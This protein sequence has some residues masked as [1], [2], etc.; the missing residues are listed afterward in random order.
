MIIR[1]RIREMFRKKA[2]KSKPP[3]AFKAAEDKTDMS[4]KLVI[5]FLFLQKEM[6]ACVYF[7]VNKKMLFYKKSLMAEGIEYIFGRKRPA[8]G[9]VFDLGQNLFV[10]ININVAH[11]IVFGAGCIFFFRKAFD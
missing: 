5:R 9:N 10:K 1:L 8:A 7:F 6:I 2:G 11:V 3:R 4:L